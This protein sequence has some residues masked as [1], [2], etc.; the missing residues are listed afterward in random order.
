[1][2][3]RVL[4]LHESVE[5]V[6]KKHENKK[7]ADKILSLNEKLLLNELIAVLEPIFQI[8]EK[9]SGQKYPTMSIILPAIE[10]LNQTVNCNF[11]VNYAFN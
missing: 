7:H 4:T 1:M 2:I 3:K 5:K 10:K 9:T 8:T 11:F 6:L